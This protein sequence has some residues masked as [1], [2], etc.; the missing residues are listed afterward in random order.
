MTAL[1]RKRSPLESTPPSSPTT[2][3]R[4]PTR[5]PTRNR[6]GTLQSR[7]TV[8]TP[9]RQMRRPLIDT[10]RTLGAG[11]DDWWSRSCRDVRPE[12]RAS[13]ECDWPRRTLVKAVPRAR[14]RS[15]PPSA[16]MKLNERTRASGRLSQHFTRCDGC[17]LL[18]TNVAACCCKT[19]N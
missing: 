10:N 11:L 13:D 14:G 5:A 6:P 8:E 1:T 18:E 16:I 19:Y 17:N 3:T 7:S 9:G 2:K 4:V 15:Q 12:T